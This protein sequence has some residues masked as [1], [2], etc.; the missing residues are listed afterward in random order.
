[1]N[2]GKKCSRSSPDLLHGLGWGEVVHLIPEIINVISIPGNIGV[3]KKI[4]YFSD[5]FMCQ[6]RLQS[7]QTFPLGCQAGCQTCECNRPQ[8]PETAKPL[9]PDFDLALLGL[10]WLSLKSTVS[11]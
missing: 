9:L 6:T 3:R 2:R 8:H 4:C 7:D 11:I 1:M 10:C 5:R